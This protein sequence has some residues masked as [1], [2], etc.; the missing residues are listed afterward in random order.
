MMSSNQRAG[1]KPEYSGSLPSIRHILMSKERRKK[2]MKP[3]NIKNTKPTK[4]IRITIKQIENKQGE[5]I[6]YYRSEL[7]N[8]TYSVYFRDNIFG[9]IAL[10]DFSEMIKRKYE[11]EDIEFILSEEKMQ[12]KSKALLEAMCL[13]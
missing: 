7:L 11:K 12:L 2:A 6:A 9:A 13:K 8:A 3:N 1:V 10:H 4:N 5:Y